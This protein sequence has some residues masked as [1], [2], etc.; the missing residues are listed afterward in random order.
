MTRDYGPAAPSC[1]DANR[2][3]GDSS[4]P[5][6]ELSHRRRAYETINHDK[7]ANGKF[8]STYHIDLFDAIQDLCKYSLPHSNSSLNTV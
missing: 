7:A 8:A 1:K 5:I 4:S 2:H 6:G 3:H